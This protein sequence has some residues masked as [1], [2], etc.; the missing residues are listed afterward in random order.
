MRKEDF[1]L[2][3]D[4]LIKESIQIIVDACILV[5]GNCDECCQEL[6]D[7]CA[8]EKAIDYTTTE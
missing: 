7:F 2:T 5:E 4:S 1:A 8:C 3:F 6:K